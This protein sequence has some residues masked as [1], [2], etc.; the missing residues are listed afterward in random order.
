MQDQQPKNPTSIPFI[1][2]EAEQVRNEHRTK[3]LLT[4]IF[5]LIFLL[6]ATNVGWLIYESQF[7]TVFVEQEV[8]TG[9]GDA[10]VAGNGDVNY[11]AHTP[12]C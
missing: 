1:V 9:N 2:Y 10:F 11:G 5:I 7:E 8:D 4:I 12:D 6:F 3:R